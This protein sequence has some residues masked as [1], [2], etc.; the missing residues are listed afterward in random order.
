[1]EI[2]GGFV[3]DFIRN[4]LYQKFSQ[5][6]PSS[7]RQGAEA[8]HKI[9]MK[10]RELYKYEYSDLGELDT[11]LTDYVS[12][13]VDFPELLRKSTTVSVHSQSVRIKSFTNPPYISYAGSYV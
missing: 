5:Y 2:Y 8:L 6:V 12:G 3:K 9:L 4:H 13:K 10:N 11:L 1:Y 7:T